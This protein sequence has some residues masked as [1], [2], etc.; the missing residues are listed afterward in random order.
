MNIFVLDKS[1]VQAALYLNDKHVVKM[2]LE[3]AQM[4]CTIHRTRWAMASCENYVWLRLH[5]LAIGEEYTFR[6]G[7]VHKSALVIAGLTLPS[8]PD[9]PQEART[10]FAMAMDT[11]YMQDCAIASYRAYYAAEKDMGWGKGRPRPTWM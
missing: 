1:P 4:L 8:L 3:S 6:Y 9:F 7:K 11:K 10:P 2:C 5:G